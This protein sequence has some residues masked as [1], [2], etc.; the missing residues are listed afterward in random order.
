MP[1][2]DRIASRDKSSHERNENNSDPIS[3][4]VRICRGVFGV[5]KARGQGAGDSCGADQSA[6]NT[7]NSNRLAD[8][9]DE[10][11]QPAA[12]AVLKHPEPAGYSRLAP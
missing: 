3:L 8:Y 5:H 4:P 12:M 6:R 1:E 2:T 11:L 10:Y 9:V 7:S